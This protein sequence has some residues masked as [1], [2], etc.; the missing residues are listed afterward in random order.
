MCM[1]FFVHH[2]PFRND[3]IN[4]RIKK[5]ISR[6]HRQPDPTANTNKSHTVCKKRNWKTAAHHSQKQGTITKNMIN[7][8][9]GPIDFLFLF[10][11]ISFPVCTLYTHIHT[12]IIKWYLSWW[13]PNFCNPTLYSLDDGHSVA[14]HGSFSVPFRFIQCIYVIRALLWNG[15]NHFLHTSAQYSLKWFYP[16]LQVMDFPWLS[17]LSRCALY[18]YLVHCTVKENLFFDIIG[19]DFVDRF[20]CHKC[21]FLEIWL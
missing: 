4:D 15:R 8:A 6:E 21:S 17:T 14:Q 12:Q 2:L 1:C 19:V 5:E 7:R 20:L 13:K 18:Y 16:E 11:S 3:N 9:K 10:A